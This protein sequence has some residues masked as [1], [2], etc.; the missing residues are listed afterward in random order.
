MQNLSKEMVLMATSLA[1]L[2]VLSTTFNNV[3]D[4]KSLVLS[5]M[6]LLQSLDWPCRCFGHGKKWSSEMQYLTAAQI[7]CSA[8][9]AEKIHVANHVPETRSVRR[10]V[11]RYVLLIL[12]AL[13]AKA[14]QLIFASCI[15]VIN[16]LCLP[17]VFLRKT[18]RRVSQR[19]NPPVLM[20][21]PP[22]G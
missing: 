1:V 21:P 6:E 8:K 20:P 12:F 22:S 19:V 13:N 16:I 3:C 7:P 10:V 5:K 4:G 14:G 15:C 2:Q 18:E 11:D 17:S 9:A